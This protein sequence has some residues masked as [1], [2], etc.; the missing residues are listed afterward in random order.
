A[1]GAGEAAIVAAQINT[2]RKRYRADPARIVV[3]GISAGAS[4]AAIMGLRYPQLVRGVFAHCGIPCGAALSPMSAL[5]VAARGPETDV[6]AIGE[7]ARRLAG[8]DLRRVALCVVQ[9]EQDNIVAPRNAA[10]LVRQYLRFNDHPAALLDPASA[11][12]R[13]DIEHHEAMSDGRIV[14]TREWRRDTALLVRYVSIAGLGHAWSGGDAKHP[15]NDPRPPS[16]T[17]L[18]AS[19]VTELG[20]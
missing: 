16:A 13:A 7:G 17:Q 19:F 10:A 15:Y 9:G 1:S 5:T 11:V 18:L 3:A 12:P 20:G 2:V 6:V 14:V 4:L 8:E